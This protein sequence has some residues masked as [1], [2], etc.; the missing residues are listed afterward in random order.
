MRKSRAYKERNEE[1]FISR[2]PKATVS[3][4]LCAKLMDTGEEGRVL[5]V[6]G[7]AQPIWH[8][9]LADREMCGSRRG[10]R[11]LPV[12]QRLLNPRGKILS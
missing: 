10:L 8:F 2:S 6:P 4:C 1:L 11:G 3:V 5:C 12:K 7:N 9:L